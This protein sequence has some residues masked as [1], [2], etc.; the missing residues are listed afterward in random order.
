[1]MVLDDLKEQMPLR[2][3]SRI[4]G[5][6]LSGYYYRPMER[7]IQRLDPSTRPRIKGIAAERPAYG[8]RRV[9]AVLRN[10][11]TRMNQ[12]TVRKVL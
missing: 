8:Y 11:G 9:W 5:I 10:Q 4:S 1:M 3:I 2:E 12:K 7:H 6:S